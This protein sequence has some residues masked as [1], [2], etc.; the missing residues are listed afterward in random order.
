M[1][2]AVAGDDFDPR[3]IIAAIGV[4]GAGYTV[5]RFLTGQRVR[6]LA[7]AGATLALAAFFKDK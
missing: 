4:V 3:K 6:P 7:L 1:K 2:T 5:Y